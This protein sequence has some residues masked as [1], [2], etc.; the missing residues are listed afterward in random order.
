MKI[1]DTLIIGGGQAGLSVGYFLHRKP[2]DFLILDAQSKPGGA[3]LKTWD[4]LMLFSPTEYSSL[5]GWPMP[6]SQNE[7]P[8]KDEFIDY[9][10]AYEKRYNFPV[11]RN[12]MVKKVTKENKLYKLH[13]TNGVYWSKTVVSATGTAEN[14]YVPYYPNRL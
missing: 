5:S 12:T 1:F 10:K 7:Y 13:T 2:I 8:D 3:W 6:K 14:P 11:K 9:L 4:S